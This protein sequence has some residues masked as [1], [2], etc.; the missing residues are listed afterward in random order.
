VT[1]LLAPTPTT[2]KCL[3]YSVH[4]QVDGVELITTQATFARSALSEL[5]T[6]RAFSRN[7]ASSRAIPVEKMLKSVTE[8]PFIP[9]RISMQQKGMHT[10]N[11]VDFAKDPDEWRKHAAIWLEIRDDVVKGVKKL[12]AAGWHKQDANR[13]LEPWLWH[14][15]IISS[16]EWENFF[17]QRLALDAHGDPL[18]YPP[19]YDLADAIDVAND[20]GWADRKIL[21]VRRPWDTQEQ[22]WHLPLTGFPGDEELSTLELCKVSAARIARTSYL[23]HDGV[24][25]VEADLRLYNDTL[26]KN[27]HWSPLEH[28]AHPDVV[29]SGNFKGW[30]QLRWYAEEGLV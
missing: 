16:T 27:G 13:A 9:R 2:A 3:A 4:G 21:R 6:H 22:Q 17:S 11:F 28:V 14:T 15:T 18:A 20:N 5:N 10:N 25:D 24:R 23:T 8:N 19:I 1:E 29:G 7:S 26:S 30:R 12:L